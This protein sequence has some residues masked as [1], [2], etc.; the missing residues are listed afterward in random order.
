M[1]V[2]PRGV[3]WGVVLDRGHEPVRLR[4][5]ELTQLGQGLYQLLTQFIGYQAAQVGW[6]PQGR[7]DPAELRHEW[8]DEIAAGELPGLVLAE[9]VLPDLRG[10][11]FVP[12][13]RGFLRIPYAGEHSSTLIS[14]EGIA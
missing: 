13:A 14:D 12:F 7:V 3:G 4:A 8:A 9:D 1:S 11:A 2:L 5:A 6:D 10:S